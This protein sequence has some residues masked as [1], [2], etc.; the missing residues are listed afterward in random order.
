MLVKVKKSIQLPPP[1]PLE[2]ARRFASLTKAE[3]YAFIKAKLDDK[4]AFRLKYTWQCWARDNQLTPT[5]NWSTWLIQAGRGYGKTRTSA[6]WVIEEAS[7]DS[8]GHIALVGR[9]V[10]DVRDV[11]VGGKSGILASSPPWFYPE[12]FPSKRKL[13]WPNGCTATT[14][15]ADS[16]DQLRGPQHT[17]AWGDERAAWPYDDAADQLQFGLRLGANPQCV[18]STTP[19]PTKAIKELIK[20]PTTFVTRGNTYE[21][22]DNL[23]KKFIREI[24]RKYSGTRLGRQEIFGDVIDDNPGALWRRDNIEAHRVSWDECPPLKRIGVAIDPATTSGEDSDETGMIVGGIAANGHA[25]ITKDLSIKAS[26]MTWARMAVDAYH[27]D[28]ADR[29]VGEGNNGGDLIETVIRTVEGGKNVSFKRVHATRGKFTRAEPIAA[30]YEQGKVHHVG[31]F[32]KLEDQQC[33]WVQGEAS[34]NN[35]DALVW[36]LTEL[37]L[38]EGKS[39]EEYLDYMR[40]YNASFW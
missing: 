17:K 32:D 8:D 36:L 40:E 20:D 26:P 30:L 5:A 18:F 16:P 25:Y 23:S 19:R 6:E 39:A 31:M 38:Q 29:I 9:T 2:F 24:E 12:Y 35:M 10:A 33:N 28:K 21:N 37:M 3:K 1:I 7:K 27:M 13:I 22:K 15:S 4:K 14:Y 11:M 34:P